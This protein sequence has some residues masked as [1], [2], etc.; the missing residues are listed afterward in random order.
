LRINFL[1]A[2]PTVLVGQQTIERI[3]TMKTFGENLEKLMKTRGLS[4]R[5]LAKQMGVPAKTVQ[6][7]VGSGG[8]MPRSPDALRQLASLFDISIHELLF[9]VP[10]P[11]G[12]IGSLL[13]KTE[14]HSGIYEI[15]VKKIK[16]KS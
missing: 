14:I 4:G 16:N 11:Q 6:E 2:K 12:M 3:T 5:T 1:Q 7:W 9:G 8:R 15:T 10:D 13:E